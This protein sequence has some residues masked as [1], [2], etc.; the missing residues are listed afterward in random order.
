MGIVLQRIHFKEFDYKY[1]VFLLFKSF[2]NMKVY[3]VDIPSDK[4]LTNFD[5][6]HYVDLLKIPNFRGVFMRD[7]L[8][9]TI[10]SIECGIMNFNTHEKYGSHWVCY[11]KRGRNRIY[12][13]SFGQVTPLEIQKY[14]KTELEFR[15]DISVIERNTDIVQRPNTHVCGHLCLFVLT[16]LMREHLTYQEVLNI[17]RDGYSQ[18]DW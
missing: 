4:R 13:D 10:K 5:I 16:S 3:E 15:N 12:F 18:D 14:L 6:L 7:E 2:I 9:T 1:Q 8:P 11:T 17:L